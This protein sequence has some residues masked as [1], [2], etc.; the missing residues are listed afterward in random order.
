M[1]KQKEYNI[2]FVVVENELK[3]LQNALRD[4]A[5]NTNNNRLQRNIA[6]N[7]LWLADNQEIT[8][9]EQSS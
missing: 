3:V 2:R 5:V 1:E 4:Y 9:N 7:L 8:Q 6:K